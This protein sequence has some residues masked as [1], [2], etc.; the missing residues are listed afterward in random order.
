M[1]KS[2]R[3]IIVTMF[4]SKKQVGL[5][6]TTNHSGKMAGMYSISTSAA[7]NKHCKE[8]AAIPGSICSHCYANALLKQRKPLAKALKANTELLTTV[9]LPIEQ[10]P[11]I[12]AH[13]F[14]YEAFGDLN[15]S[16]QV[17]N[18]FNICRKNPETMFA[19][20]T[21]NP[22][23][24]AN[25]INDGAEKPENMI[26]IYSSPIIGDAVKLADIQKNFSFVDKVFTVYESE[27]QAAEQ[28]KTIN[29]GSR[30]C[31]TCLKCYRKN[32]IDEISELLK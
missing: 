32:G 8:R 13:S 27:E 15:N 9:L 12:N 30:S 31:I 5:H 22:F 2:I 7:E 29:C 28:G 4:N 1:K 14:R 25:A 3:E 11:V 16:V 17:K 10:L 21:K 20:W 6:V 23:I 19:L 24:I 26:V 18:Y